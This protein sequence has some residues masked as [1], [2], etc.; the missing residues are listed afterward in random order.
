[1]CLVYIKLFLDI[2]IGFEVLEFSPKFST[3]PYSRKIGIFTYSER[4]RKNTVNFHFVKFIDNQRKNLFPLFT[5][6]LLNVSIPNLHTM[7]IQSLRINWQQIH[8]QLCCNFVTRF[9]RDLLRQTRK[10]L[11]I[12]SLVA[13]IASSIYV[14]VAIVPRA[15]TTQGLDIVICCQLNIF[16]RKLKS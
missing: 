1:M 5:C 15:I 8:A 6:Q 12:A 9:C 7:I 2:T 14:S 3:E 11:S 10:Y 4:R 13:I 16:S